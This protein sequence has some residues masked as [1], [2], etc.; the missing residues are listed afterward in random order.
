M[1]VLLYNWCL[2]HFGSPN[3]VDPR[4]RTVS[5]TIVNRTTGT[6]L[7]N[8]QIQNSFR[9]SIAQKYGKYYKSIYTPEC[10]Q[11]ENHWCYVNH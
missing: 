3:T 5:L 7:L 10:F 2:R 8:R 4:G 1:Q 9:V 6:H 11:N